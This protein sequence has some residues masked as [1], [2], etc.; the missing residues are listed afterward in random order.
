MAPSLSDFPLLL[1]T[2]PSTS[3]FLLGII[4][5]SSFQFSSIKF[6]F[7]F[8]PPS[9]SLWSSCL[10]PLPRLLS[11]LHLFFPPQPSLSEG[12]AQQLSELYKFFFIIISTT[13]SAYYVVVLFFFPSHSFSVAHC[14]FY[15]S[16]GRPDIS[17]LV[18]VCKRL[19]CIFTTS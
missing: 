10:S 6:L 13:L 7:F 17:A 5:V 9:L 12:P 14:D 18:C 1:F 16:S 8:P 19:F 15:L 4:F 3:L 11:F 2:S